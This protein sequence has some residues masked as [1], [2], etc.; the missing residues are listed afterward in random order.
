[1]E[2]YSGISPKYKEIQKTQ[3]IYRTYHQPTPHYKRAKLILENIGAS[4]F[5][6]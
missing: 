6:N 5:T 4:N 1:M 2:N 3:L